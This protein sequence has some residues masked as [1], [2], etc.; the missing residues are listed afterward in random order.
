MVGT[1]KF[2]V[3]HGAI[4]VDAV[5]YGVDLHGEKPLLSHELCTQ[6]KLFKTSES[7]QKS[8]NYVVDKNDPVFKGLGCIKNV[9]YHIRI[10]EGAIPRCFPVGRLAP[11]FVDSV[12]KE[13]NTMLK[14]GVLV[15][16]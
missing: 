1:C 7:V 14:Q 5:F 8:I 4:K 9:F 13:I 3:S 11:A 15:P 16:R 12:Q 2:E 10:K 6:L